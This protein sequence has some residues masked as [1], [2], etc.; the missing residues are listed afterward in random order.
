[1]IAQGTDGLSRGD[2]SE[3]VMRGDLMLQHVPL[4][5]TCL[6]RS[7]ALKDWLRNIATPEGRGGVH[8]LS[9]ADWFERGHD[10]V[11]GE[12]NDDGV[13]VPNYSSGTLIWTPS[14]AGAWTAVEQLRRAR[15][16]REF[17]THIFVVPHLMT[18]EWRRQ[19]FRVS[20]MC[21]E[22]PFFEEWNQ[23]EQHEPL[24]IA[25]VF[26]FLSFRP[27]QLKR[28]RGYVA[29]A[30][31]LR[32]LWKEAPAS[33]GHLLRQFCSFTWS[34]AGMQEGMVRALLRRL[35][36][37][38]VLRPS[39]GKRARSSVDEEGEERGSKVPRRN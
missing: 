31:V 7:P 36:D 29:M 8:F 4:H 21:I 17:S 34:L 25:F 12:R 39:S 19:L 2:C 23:K 1:M 16:K 14:P 32:Q 26:P 13:Y 9:T 22:L 35:P 11:G 20:D 15:V 24:T 30:G 10:I 37:P 38:G 27:W 3:G 28:C 33:T 5:L 6:Q 18:P